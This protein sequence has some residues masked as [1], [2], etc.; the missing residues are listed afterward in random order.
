MGHGWD[1]GWWSIQRQNWTAWP[2]KGRGLLLPVPTGLLPLL[3]VLAGL[4]PSPASEGLA[5]MSAS[6]TDS[7]A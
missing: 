6:G 4:L 5:W 7:W 1:K 3:T 2:S